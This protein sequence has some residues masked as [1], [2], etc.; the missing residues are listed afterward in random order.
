MKSVGLIGLGNIGS[1]YVEKLREA[2][3]PLTVFDIDP[4]GG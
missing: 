2:D 1:Y 3:Y 4:E